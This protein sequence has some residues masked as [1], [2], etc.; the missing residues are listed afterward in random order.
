MLK[1]VIEQQQAKETEIVEE[2][3]QLR[4]TLYTVQVE[5]EGLL[6]KHS[7]LK[8]SANVRPWTRTCD[9]S[10]RYLA[11][12]MFVACANKIIFFCCV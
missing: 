7:N 2:N 6:K 3:E 1:E 10:F 11:Q 4:R 9:V 5:L 12:L 8:N